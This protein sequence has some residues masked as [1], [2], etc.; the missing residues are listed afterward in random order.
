MYT[1]VV[2]VAPNAGSDRVQC[3]KTYVFEKF[4][5]IFLLLKSVLFSIFVENFP[6]KTNLA[7]LI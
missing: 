6:G 7:N 3:K 2:Y 4:S 1:T 5:E